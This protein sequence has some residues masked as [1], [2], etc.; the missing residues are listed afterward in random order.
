MA[1]PFLVLGGIAVGVITATFGVLQVPGWVASAQEAAALNDI[2]HVRLAEEAAGSGGFGYQSGAEL[3]ANADDIGVSMTSSS[4][5]TLCVTRNDDRSAHAAVAQAETGKYFASVSGGKIGEGTSPHLALVDAGG[6]PDGVPAPYSPTGCAAGAEVPGGSN[7]APGH[8]DGGSGLDMANVIT[9][10]LNC[11]TTA[12][13]TLPLVNMNGELRWSDGE[14]QSATGA[15]PTREL[16]GGEHRAV[17]FHGTFDTFDWANSGRECIRSID[18]WRSNSSTPFNL[19]FAFWGM[20]NL[21]SVPAEIP[22]VVSA[23][24]AFNGASQ[25]NSDISGWD[26]S[27]VTNTVSM[28]EG[29]ASFNQPIGSWNVG[30]VDDMG[31]MFSGATS[32]NQPIGGWDTSSATNFDSMF[33]GATSFN[34]PIGT[35]NTSNVTTMRYMFNGASSFNQ[36]ISGWNVSNVTNTENFS[37][38]SALSPAHLPHFV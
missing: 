16:P 34:R 37:T 24:S 33:A 36:D 21:T 38:G 5:V 9:F 20:S 10:G 18:E 23:M 8:P 14:E 6:I 26:M 13:F 35:W 7:A 30:N 2:S 31:A 25:F 3:A 17:T 1:N 4:G 19:N 15:S 11:P 27:Q 22:P 28:F 12:T 29:A 32:F